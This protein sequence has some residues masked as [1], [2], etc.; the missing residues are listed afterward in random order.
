MRKVIKLF[1]KGNVCVFG[2]RG[3]GKDLLTGNVIVRRK[4]PYVSN[5][6]YGGKHN[7]FKYSEI[8]VGG[9]TYKDFISGNIK[10]YV[11]PYV[12]GTDVYLS[13][14]GVYF[15]SQYCNELNKD[16]RQIATFQALSRHVGDCN[17]HINAQALNRVFDKI[18]E[19][20]DTYILCRG[21]LYIKGINLVIQRITVYDNYESAVSKREP[22]NVP[23]PLFANKEMKLHK[24]IQE[25]NYKAEHGNI[26]KRLIFY[27][28]KST[29]NTRYFK[30]LL[31]NGKEKA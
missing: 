29:Y 6:N 20:S 31:K 17:F 3:S 4:L 22:L 8:D 11:Y 10:K 13:D 5:I 30:E 27:I 24:R 16:Y 1:E 15:P 19:Q 7:D 2:L 18:R 21:V 26:K 23:L 9:N 28:N 12:D 14:G 25:A